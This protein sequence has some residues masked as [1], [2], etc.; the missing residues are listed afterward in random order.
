MNQIYEKWSELI[1]V[2]IEFGGQFLRNPLFYAMVLLVIIIFFALYELPRN[3]KNMKNSVIGLLNYTA[4]LLLGFIGDILTAIESI[5]NFVDVISI[6]LKGKLTEGTQFLLSNYA[7]I[8]L[9]VASFITTFTGLLEITSWYVAAMVTFGIQVGIL[10]MS[11]KIAIEWNKKK[12]QKVKASKEISFYIKQDNFNWNEIEQEKNIFQFGVNTSQSPWFANDLNG[13]GIPQLQ[14]GD[15]ENRHS[16]IYIIIR[17]VFLIFSMCAS[18]YFSYVFLFNKAVK[19]NLPLD[20]YLAALSTITDTTNNYSQALV[21]IQNVLQRDLQ[22]FNAEI[23]GESDFTR[24]IT[25]EQNREETEIRLSDFN[26]R[27]LGLDIEIAELERLQD[28]AFLDGNDEAAN[29]YQADITSLNITRNTLES[30][31]VALTE[32]LNEL[33]ASDNDSSY[34]ELRE[35]LRALEQLDEFYANTSYLLE[36][37]EESLNMS[38][39]LGTLIAYDTRIKQ[40]SNIEVEKDKYSDLETILNN[41]LELYQYYKNNGQVGFDNSVMQDALNSE[42]FVLQ[43][44]NDSKAQD[45]EESGRQELDNSMIQDA[46]NEAEDDVNAITSK[47]IQEMIVAV[48]SVPDIKS[49]SSMGKDA[50][51]CINNLEKSQYLTYLYSLYRVSTGQVNI[52][53]LVVIRLQMGY[54]ALSVLIFFLAAFVDVLAVILNLTRSTNVYENRLPRYRKL[55]YRMF[56]QDAL[57]DFDKQRIKRAQLAG[58]ISIAVGLLC[59]GYYYNSLNDAVDGLNLTISLICSVSFW[60]LIG[61][62]LLNLY[63]KIHYDSNEWE[64]ERFY[65]NLKTSWNI[66]SQDAEDPE[67]LV[68]RIHQARMNKIELHLTLDD[69]RQIIEL[70]QNTE[71]EE[72][73]K[74]L[75][76]SARLLFRHIQILVLN[77][78]TLEYCLVSPGLSSV[79]QYMHGWYD[80]N[81]F[82][83]ISESEVRRM[84]MSMTFAILKAENLVEYA[85]IVETEPPKNMCFNA[86]LE[87]NESEE[88]QVD[89]EKPAE[90]EV[91]VYTGKSEESEAQDNAEVL[92]NTEVLKNSIT[93]GYYILSQRFLRLLFELIMEAVSGTGFEDDYSFIDHLYDVYEEDDIGEG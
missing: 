70:L 23:R 27:I 54:V 5:T 83:C 29:N 12:R 63:E 58:G 67:S 33:A 53:E 20:T 55:L 21:E 31:R 40:E 2:L 10:S 24:V 6:I 16:W 84:G 44:F 39:S 65:N 74:A 61:H 87:D 60:A 91:Q 3:K 72:Y 35:V 43:A 28:N 42:K 48:N 89:A 66:S 46:Q 18:I 34:R 85:E 88:A 56:I 26:D 69:E 75:K 30:D 1:D 14:R 93:K 15:D 57:S 47:I 7:I 17:S 90:T 51:N 38:S 50:R 79:K 32:A 37:E 64:R 73:M 45:T 8:A 68:G 92:E 25:T 78:R 52:L 76:P 41:Y 77:K 22:D 62:V 71:T 82:P 19:P 36:N 13:I 81:D 11:S 86:I 4:K 49:W 9:S 59:F 80:E